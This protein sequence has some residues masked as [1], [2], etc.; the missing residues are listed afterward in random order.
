MIVKKIKNVWKGNDTVKVRFMMSNHTHSKIIEKMKV[1]SGFVGVREWWYSTRKDM[2]GFLFL[3]FTV[4]HF[5]TW[6][7]S[8]FEL[9]LYGSLGDVMV[10]VTFFLCFTVLVV[11]FYNK[12]Q[13]DIEICFLKHAFINN[14]LENNKIKRQ[15]REE[16][17]EK[18]NGHIFVFTSFRRR[19]NVLKKEIDALNHL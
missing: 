5:V 19:S 15:E 11:F 7:I 9:W 14:A 10:F 16:L 3:C 6:C 13:D 12:N 2:V 1:I 4:F 18:I 17:K 8:F